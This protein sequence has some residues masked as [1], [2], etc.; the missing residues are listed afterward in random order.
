MKI[1]CEIIRDILP[2]YAED[3]V[4][5]PTRAMVEEHLGECKTCT[6]ELVSLRMQATPAESG[7]TALKRVKD[8]IRRRRVLSVL[9]A[10]FMIQPRYRY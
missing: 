7:V 3:M 10:I 5:Q 6:K 9:A 1:P 4:S 8:A 2:L